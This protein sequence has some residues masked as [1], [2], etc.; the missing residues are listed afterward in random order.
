MKDKVFMDTAS[1]KTVKEMADQIQDGI[2]IEVEMTNPDGVWYK[3]E[4]LTQLLGSMAFVNAYA[5][6]QYDRARRELLVNGIVPRSS[7]TGTIEAE[8][9]AESSFF[10]LTEELQ[11]NLRDAVSATQSLLSHLKVEQRNTN[12]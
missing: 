11:R 6:E 10:K 5:K 3:L 4:A 12:F 8:M 2:G 1:F 7:S 9:P